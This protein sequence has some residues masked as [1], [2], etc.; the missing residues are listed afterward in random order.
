MAKFLNPPDP[1]IISR[2]VRRAEELGVYIPNDLASVSVAAFMEWLTQT[3]EGKE[4][5][6]RLFQFDW[7][8]GETDYEYYVA[9]TNEKVAGT[10]IYFL[11]TAVVKGRFV[12]MSMIDE[13]KVEKNGCDACGIL[14]HC[15][16]LISGKHICNFCLS[17]TDNPEHRDKSGGSR[18]CLGCTVLLCQ[19]HPSRNIHKIA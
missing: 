2:V 7:Q 15:T 11:R 8:S 6:V 5:F 9:D 19:H 12:P 13:H 14:S 10:D 1:T 17:H 4:F 16:R 3:T 18:E